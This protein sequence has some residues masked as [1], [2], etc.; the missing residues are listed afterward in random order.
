MKPF[1][2][3]DMLQKLRTRLGLRD[4]DI[5]YIRYLPRKVRAD[6]FKPNRICAVWESVATQ[7]ADLGFHA[8][9]ITRIATRLESRGL[10]LRTASKGGRRFGRRGP[11]DSIVVAGGINLGPLIEKAG[12]LVRHIRHE[13]LETARLRE[14]RDRANDLIKAIRALDAQEALEAARATFPRLRPSE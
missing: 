3:P 2:L 10:V 11:D 13:A 14:H 5:T 7:A 6:D 9:R 1:D 8:R 12:D 4:E